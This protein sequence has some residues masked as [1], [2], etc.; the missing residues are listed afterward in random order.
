MNL[1]AELRTLQTPVAAPDFTGAIMTRVEQVDATQVVAPERQVD[2]IGQRLSF[3]AVLAGVSVGIALMLFSGALA[4]AF[5]PLERKLAA[6]AP[7]LPGAAL[8]PLALV[9]G[10]LIYLSS[11]W[12]SVASRR[13]SFSPE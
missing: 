4:T 13:E 3:T 5:G 10:G 2:S 1:A 7:M 6:A 11:L 12:L 9:V 8:G